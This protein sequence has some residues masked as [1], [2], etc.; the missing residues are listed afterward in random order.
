MFSKSKCRSLL[1]A[2]ILTATAISAYAQQPIDGF[3]PRT[4]SNS[5]GAKM[6]YRLFIPPAYDA[7]HS[8]PLI[9]YLHGGAGNGT[10]NVSQI[11]GG[12]IEGTHVWT[13]M[14]VAVVGAPLAAPAAD[15]TIGAEATC[16]N[17]R[18]ASAKLRNFSSIV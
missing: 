6:P 11:S 12:N 18:R 5:N 10:D 14:E 4:F 2:V 8:Y 15:Q 17:S 9:V 3:L 1:A 13:T 7:T 16:P